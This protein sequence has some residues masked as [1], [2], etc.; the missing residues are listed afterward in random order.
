MRTTNGKL[1]SDLFTLDNVCIKYFF[2]FYS[3][4]NTLDHYHFPFAIN[5]SSSIFTGDHLSDYFQNF[6]LFA[7]FFQPH[8]IVAYYGIPFFKTTSYWQAQNLFLLN[9]SQSPILF[10]FKIFI[11]NI[12][13]LLLICFKN[14]DIKW[15]EFGSK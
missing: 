1:T 15:R 14:L 8:L 10:A 7:N 4:F 12:Y 6:L 5:S 11:L 13:F 2:L 9:Y 3:T